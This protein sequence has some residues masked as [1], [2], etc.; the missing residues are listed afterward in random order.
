MA[1]DSAGLAAQPLPATLDGWTLRYETPA[2]IV[3][4]TAPFTFKDLALP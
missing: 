2:R 1:A 3:E 4:L